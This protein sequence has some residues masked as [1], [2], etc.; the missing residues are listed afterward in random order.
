MTISVGAERDTLELLSISILIYC[1]VGLICKKRKKVWSLVSLIGNIKLGNGHSVV[2]FKQNTLYDC[3]RDVLTNLSGFTLVLSIAIY[4]PCYYS[5]L[6]LAYQQ[7]DQRK[8]QNECEHTLT[9][10]EA[11]SIEERGEWLSKSGGHGERGE[12][13]FRLVGKQQLKF[14]CCS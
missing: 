8:L 5:S 11:A 13:C 9:L 3:M 1:D 10:L 2:L 7:S 4:I 14:V 6:F 12:M